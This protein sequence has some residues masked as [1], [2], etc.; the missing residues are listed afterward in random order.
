[1][2]R[3]LK[4]EMLGILWDWSCVVP[5]VKMTNSVIKKW[6]THLRHILEFAL[7]VLVKFVLWQ[8]TEKKIHFMGYELIQSPNAYVFAT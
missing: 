7:K 5:K 3:D 8:W 2:S 6:E 1:M 4:M